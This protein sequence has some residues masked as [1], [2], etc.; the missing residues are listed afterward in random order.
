MPRRSGQAQRV[1]MRGSPPARSRGQSAQPADK[2][3]AE[4][5]QRFNRFWESLVAGSQTW[6]CRPRCP[7]RCRSP[8][9]GP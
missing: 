6:T 5:I 3:A 8:C 2:P 7:R 9:R 1:R 4:T